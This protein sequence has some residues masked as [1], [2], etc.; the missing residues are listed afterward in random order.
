V[1]LCEDFSSSTA[2]GKL[3][4]IE[5]SIEDVDYI[6]ESKS[7]SNKILVVKN[8]LTVNIIAASGIASV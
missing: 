7:P 5:T 1:F 6:R 4:L 3:D 2:C 8:F